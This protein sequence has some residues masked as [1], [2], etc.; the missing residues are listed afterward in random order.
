MQSMCDQFL[1]GAGAAMKP[2]KMEL[3]FAAARCGMDEQG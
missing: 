3:D 1:T 2:V